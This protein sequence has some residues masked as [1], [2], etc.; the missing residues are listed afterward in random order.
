VK[1]SGPP[2]WTGGVLAGPAPS[3]T[4]NSP[5]AYRAGSTG[6]DFKDAPPDGTS[7]HPSDQLVRNIRVGL[8]RAGHLRQDGQLFPQPPSDFVVLV[9]APT[10][11]HS[12]VARY[13]DPKRLRAAIPH[14]DRLAVLPQGRFVGELGYSDLI[15]RFRRQSRWFTRAER[16][17]AGDLADYL[18]FKLTSPNRPNP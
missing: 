13:R 15:N 18:E 11:G 5:G 16:R 12:L 9:I 14:S 8:H 6:S 17:I 3:A 2:G 10:Q 4:I 1:A 7:G